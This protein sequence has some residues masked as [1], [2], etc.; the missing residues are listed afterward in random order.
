MCHIGPGDQRRLGG[1]GD[2]GCSRLG[3][4]DSYLGE[5][6]E[7]LIFVSFILLFPPTQIIQTKGSYSFLLCGMIMACLGFILFIGLLLFQ[8]MHRNYL[9]GIQD[10]LCL[11]R[12]LFHHIL[13]QS[14]TTESL[15]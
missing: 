8:R 6:G 12:M 15:P 7:C 9:T 10:V 1:D 2:S 14:L 3:K 11:F 5:W 13:I 4:C